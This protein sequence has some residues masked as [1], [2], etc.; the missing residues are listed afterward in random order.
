M[1]WHIRCRRCCCE[2]RKTAPVSFSLSKW[3]LTT[4]LHSGPNPKPQRAMCAEE[5]GREASAGPL[6]RRAQ[7]RICISKWCDGFLMETTAVNVFRPQIKWMWSKTATDRKTSSSSAQHDVTT[8][9]RT[10]NMS[11]KPKRR[12]LTINHSRRCEV[13]RSVWHGVLKQH[14]AERSF[15]S[16]P[17]TMPTGKPD[18]LATGG[19]I[20]QT[21]TA[22]WS[23]RP[24]DGF[25]MT[26]SST[27][28]VCEGSK[29]VDRIFM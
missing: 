16:Q 21:N 4:E 7:I 8:Q 24:T 6:D 15:E 10:Q 3:W 1:W 29:H 9:R 19:T 26:M 23:A 20:Q 17:L 12:D 5:G 13:Q 18:V 14:C 22:L 2:E 28:Q 27:A 11:S 25:Q